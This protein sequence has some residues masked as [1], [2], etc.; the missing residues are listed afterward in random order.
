MEF[1]EILASIRK[2]HDATQE[3][4]ADYL[5]VSRST[6]AGY[7]TRGR[8]PEYYLLIKI[9]DFFGVS[10][11]TLLGHT[12]A[13]LSKEDAKHAAGSAMPREDL[14]SL[15]DSPFSE[16]DFHSSSG[17]NTLNV[18]LQ[19]SDRIKQLNK[20]VYCAASLSS[21]DFDL[22]HVLCQHMSDTKTSNK[23]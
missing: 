16:T 9:A 15:Q 5:K 1:G 8:E 17:N 14:N 10:I 12:G 2:E 19:Y 23:Q 22:L 4:L 20:L 21:R 11:D 18:Q 13:A 7:E 6:I 3:E